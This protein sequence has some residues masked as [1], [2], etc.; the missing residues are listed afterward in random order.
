[1]NMEQ[2]NLQN[3]I[4]L[5]YPQSGLTQVI[6]LPNLAVPNRSGNFIKKGA[7]R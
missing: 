6:T 4:R 7:G 3:K 5:K 2:L 1:M